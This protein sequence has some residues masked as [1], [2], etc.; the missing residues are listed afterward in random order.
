MVCTLWLIACIVDIRWCTL[1][2]RPFP[3]QTFL[4][5]W[6]SAT[7]THKGTL[8][9]PR[10]LN[11]HFKE[12]HFVQRP[13]EMRWKK[14]KKSSFSPALSAQ[15][16]STS[17]SLSHRTGGKWGWFNGVQ[18]TE[19]KR[20]S[21]WGEGSGGRK[22]RSQREGI[23]SGTPEGDPLCLIGWLLQLRT[24]YSVLS[25]FWKA[26]LGRQVKIYCIPSLFGVIA[27]V[28]VTLVN[29]SSYLYMYWGLQRERERD[30]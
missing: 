25:E 19:P 2:S 18:E 8:R 20:T 3:S 28:L 29:L 14:G 15:L 12:S 23:V 5:F 13:F 21:V 26:S 27:G 9:L 7:I 16:D 30:I 4:T 17:V 22:E 24:S 11:Q 10:P 1:E 6:T